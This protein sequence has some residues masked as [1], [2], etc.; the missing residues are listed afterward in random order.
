MLR[1][2]REIRTMNGRLRKSLEP[3]KCDIITYSHFTPIL[4][5]KYQR[6][7]F[8]IYE[9]VIFVKCRLF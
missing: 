9:N 6:K 8:K 3:M 7:K 2:I 1:S 5:F 4:K